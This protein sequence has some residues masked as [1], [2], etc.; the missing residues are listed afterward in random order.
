[1]VVNSRERLEE[2]NISVMEFGVCPPN[3]SFVSF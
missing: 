2:G 1:M 3:Q